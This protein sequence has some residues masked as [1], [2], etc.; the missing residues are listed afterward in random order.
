[1]SVKEV[2]MMVVGQDLRF[3]EHRE[4]LFIYER[5]EG[6]GVV[7][8]TL[9]RHEPFIHTQVF[10]FHCI[11]AGFMVELA[12]YPES[13]KVKGSLSRSGYTTGCNSCI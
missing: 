5:K 11:V 9:S 12:Q 3:E 4:I 10:I 1:M 6:K 2:L 13:R 8:R 7:M